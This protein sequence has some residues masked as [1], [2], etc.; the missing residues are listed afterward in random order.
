[1]PCVTSHLIRENIERSWKHV[2]ACGASVV[3]EFMGRMSQ[4]SSSYLMEKSS[5]CY[6]YLRRTTSS[7]MRWHFSF[8][9]PCL[10]RKHDDV[11]ANDARIQLHEKWYLTCKLHW[12]ESLIETFKV[13]PHVLL[14]EFSARFLNWFK[15]V[16]HIRCVAA[17]FKWFLRER[18]F[19]HFYRA[20][21]SS[22]AGLQHKACFAC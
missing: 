15:L 22:I 6:L 4:T 3:F 5:F 1:M 19:I 20:E 8:S 12:S 9:F 14:S 11:N 18:C 17:R 21:K 16:S 7:G 10:Q 2:V 13:W